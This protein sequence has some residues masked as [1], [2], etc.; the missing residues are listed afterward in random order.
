MYLL[1]LLT[2]LRHLG[3]SCFVV[4]VFV[5]VFVVVFVVVGVVAGV[6]VVV[7]PAD[8]AVAAE[9]CCHKT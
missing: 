6:A 9:C 1:M 2:L 7:G 5:A 4:V 8:V 3:F